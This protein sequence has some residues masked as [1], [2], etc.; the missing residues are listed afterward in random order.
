M[1]KTEIYEEKKVTMIEFDRKGYVIQVQ[2]YA[3]E[4]YEIPLFKALKEDYKAKRFGPGQK[5]FLQSQHFKW[6]NAFQR[7]AH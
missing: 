3:R 2:N 4:Q 5:D 1:D 7:V 6:L